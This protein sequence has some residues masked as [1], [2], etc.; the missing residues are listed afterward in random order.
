LFLEGLLLLMGKEYEEGKGIMI[1]FFQMR[2]I[3]MLI[4]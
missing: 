3:K 4:K 1:D 2:N